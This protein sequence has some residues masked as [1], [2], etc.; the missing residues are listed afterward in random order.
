LFDLLRPFNLGLVEPFNQS[1]QMLFNQG[2]SR[3]V[4]SIGL[5]P[6]PWLLA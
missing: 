4:S 1:L 2:V 5:H 3:H 6:K